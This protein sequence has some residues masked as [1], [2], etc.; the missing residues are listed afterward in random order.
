MP[1]M[2]RYFLHAAYKEHFVFLVASMQ[3]YDTI[4]KNCPIYQKMYRAR[5]HEVFL[6]RGMQWMA[7]TQ[8]M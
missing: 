1:P 2:K 5:K 7:A 3:K 4:C 8:L 6:V